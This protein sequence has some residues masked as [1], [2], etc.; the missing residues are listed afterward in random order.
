MRGGTQKSAR[1]ADD[2]DRRNLHSLTEEASRFQFW[3]NFSLRDAIRSE[4]FRPPD[5]D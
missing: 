2:G 3:G 1:L 4:D 5:M